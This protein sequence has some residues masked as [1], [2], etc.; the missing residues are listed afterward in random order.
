[1]LHLFYYQEL[2]KFI[3]RFFL[4]VHILENFLETPIL[5]IF[6]KLKVTL[7]LK[8]EGRK[9]NKGVYFFKPR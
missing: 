8:V 3:H 9:N 6:Q 7:V 5:P 4:I 1:M 2:L